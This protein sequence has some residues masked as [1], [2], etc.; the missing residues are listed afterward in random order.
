MARKRAIMAAA[1][2]MTILIPF[3]FAPLQ[4][5]VAQHEYPVIV[6]HLTVPLPNPAPLFVVTPEVVS[7]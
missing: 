4:R 5:S 2:A 3:I 6:E 1:I 7:D